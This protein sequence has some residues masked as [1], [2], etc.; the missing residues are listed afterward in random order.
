MKKFY[1]L[2]IIVLSG[3]YI[4]AQSLSGHIIDS[5]SR[6]PIEGGSVYIPQLRLGAATDRSGAYS[7][8]SL[9]KGGYDV[10]VVGPGNTRR[11]VPVTT[12]IFDDA[13]GLVQV[14]GALGPGQRVVVAA[15]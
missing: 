7:I 6:R 12:G 2:A 14:T 13:D 15:S 3:L 10:E 8:P 11:Y 5:G 4:R 9:P 1:L